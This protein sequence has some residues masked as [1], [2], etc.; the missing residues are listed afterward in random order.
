M[1]RFLCNVVAIDDYKGY[2]VANP[3]FDSIGRLLL[4]INFQVNDKTKEALDNQDI[5]FIWLSKEK[6]DEIEDENKPN[7]NL[8]T[9]KSKRNQL[10]KTFDSIK[11]EFSLKQKKGTTKIDLSKKVLKKVEDSISS[12]LDQ[13]IENP[14]VAA[15]LEPLYCDADFLVK[16]SVNSTYFGLCMLAGYPGL[17]DILK[18]PEKGLPRFQSINKINPISLELTSFGM[19]CF[20]HD[21]GK[22]AILD[23]VS[24]EKHYNHENE[25]NKEIWKKIKRHP[26]EGHD[27]LFGKQIDA[28]VLLGIKYHHENFDGSGYPFGVAGYKIHP[29]SRMLRVID[30]FDA[31]ISRGPGRSDK[32]F[33]EILGELLA[34][35]GKNYDT[36]IVKYFVDMLLGGKSGLVSKGIVI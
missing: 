35:S 27:M 1:S 34:L 29:F 36:E 3:I 15:T 5:D 26:V 25:E 9:L 11:E 18:D 28:H 7:R 16:H 21:I 14:F 8:V 22:L 17:R 10:Q 24:S 6:I 19:T 13:I 2:Y 23:I 4:N 12:I 33:K 30:S 20:L 31:A 32:T